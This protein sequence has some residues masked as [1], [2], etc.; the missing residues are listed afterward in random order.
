VINAVCP[1][2]PIKGSLPRPLSS[3]KSQQPM[4]MKKKS[5]ATKRDDGR[6]EI[7]PENIS[8]GKVPNFTPLLISKPSQA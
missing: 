7:D 1:S 5:R 8:T 2:N 4:N 3:K 6:D